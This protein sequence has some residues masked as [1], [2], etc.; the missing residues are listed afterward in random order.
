MAS[1][2]L[3]STDHPAVREVGLCWVFRKVVGVTADMCCHGEVPRDVQPLG[4]LRPM[5][6]LW[7]PCWTP[8]LFLQV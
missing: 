7:Y 1:H 5:T 4:G 8:H 2:T 6:G 3:S